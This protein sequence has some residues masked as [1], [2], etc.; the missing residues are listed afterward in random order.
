VFCIARKTHVACFK[1]ILEHFST[2]SEKEYN[3]KI[4]SIIL[5]DLNECAM[6]LSAENV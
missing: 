1:V 6:L 3:T 2:Q 4:A 5:D